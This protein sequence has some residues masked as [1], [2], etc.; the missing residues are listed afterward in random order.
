[1]MTK[2]ATWRAG[3]GCWDCCGGRTRKQQ[4]RLEEKQWRTEYNKEEALTTNYVE[5]V[6]AKLTKELPEL[7]YDLGMLYALLVFV[8]GKDVTL[9]D[10]HDAWSIWR[11]ETNQTHKS[12]IP[13]DELTEEVQLLDEKYAAGIRAAAE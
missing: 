6:Y 13:F 10:V 3:C 8:K 12:L 1:M 4:R 7:D 2:A 9:E 11:N 5:E